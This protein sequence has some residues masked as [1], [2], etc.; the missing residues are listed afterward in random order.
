[1]DAFTKLVLVNAIHFKSEWKEPFY[2][3]DTEKRDFTLAS[4]N[5]VW[6]VLFLESF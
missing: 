3:Q 4:G 1:M 5:K 2:R 6:L